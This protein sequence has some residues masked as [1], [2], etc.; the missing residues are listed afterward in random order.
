MR[1]VYH[2]IKTGLGEAGPKEMETERLKC[3]RVGSLSVAAVLTPVTVDFAL[4]DD[5][6]IA[7]DAFYC[8]DTLAA[9]R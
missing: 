1:D 3:W 8:T 7:R 2:L 9:G 4:N 6:E 5:V